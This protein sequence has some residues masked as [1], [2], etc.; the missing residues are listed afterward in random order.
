MLRNEEHFIHHYDLFN[1]FATNTTKYDSN[2]SVIW[3]MNKVIQTLQ[4]KCLITLKSHRL[5]KGV[6][7]LLEFTRETREA[8]KVW[9]P[10]PEPRTSV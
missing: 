3:M 5:C 1:S 6:V 8:T 4:H 10:S 9:I 7:L 2:Y